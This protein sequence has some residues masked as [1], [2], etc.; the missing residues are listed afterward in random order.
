MRA[1]RGARQRMVLRGAK[2]ILKEQHVFIHNKVVTV[3]FAYYDNALLQQ[4][5][6]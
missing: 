2:T 1:L 3:K 6:C 4:V 5:L